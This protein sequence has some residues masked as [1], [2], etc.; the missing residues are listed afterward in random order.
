MGGK[1]KSRS[2]ED[3]IPKWSNSH[4]RS[5]TRRRRGNLSSSRFLS[6]FGNPSSPFLLWRKAFLNKRI[7]EAERF[8]RSIWNGKRL[9]I[10][11]ILIRAE[12]KGSE[13]EFFLKLNLEIAF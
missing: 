8:D 10:F 7:R 11:E 4:R 9:E 1:G 2:R 3:S 13:S 5:C 6:I 12:C